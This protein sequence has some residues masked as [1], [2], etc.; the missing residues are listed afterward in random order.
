MFNLFKRKT[1]R[2]SVTPDDQRWTEEQLLWLLQLFGVER[3][4]QRPFLRPDAATFPYDDLSRP[5]Q[6]QQLL[7]QLLEQLCGYWEIEADNITVRLYEDHIAQQMKSTVMGGQFTQLNGL[8]QRTGTAEAPHYLIH[9]AESNLL[10]AQRLVAV[11]AHELAHV[12]LLGGGYLT[13]ETPYMEPLTDLATIYFGFGLL[14]ANTCERRDG[15]VGRGGYLPNEIISYANALLCLVAGQPAAQYLPLLNTNTRALLRQD[16]AFLTHG[17]DTTFTHDTL[18]RIDGQYR[19]W[20]RVGDAQ[21]RRDFAALLA[22][23]EEL[24][25]LDAKDKTALN[26]LGYTLLQLGRYPEAIAAFNRAIDA[27]PYWDY[28]YNNRGYCLLQLGR[29]EEAYVDLHSSFLMNPGNSFSWRNLGA[30]HLATGD[31]AEALR[32]FEEARRLDPAT[33]MIHFYLAQA[34][35]QLGHAERAAGHAAQSQAADE[36]NDS[37]LA[38]LPI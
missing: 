13:H 12:K 29:P 18:T 24:I 19:A 32:H 23:Y 8:Y 34:H 28:P 7:E 33:E 22:A 6:L 31:Y 21:P 36:H 14:M 4:R 5:A 15:W 38:S 10:D 20:L 27:D 2:P 35:H 37:V 17:G 1:Y 11:L 26:N 25:R 3:V 16:Y 30:Y 9:L